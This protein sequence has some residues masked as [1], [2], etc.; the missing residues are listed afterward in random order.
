MKSKFI[1]NLLILSL[2]NIKHVYLLRLDCLEAIS[3]YSQMR[4]TIRWTAEVLYS[5]FGDI[6]LHCPNIQ[7]EQAPCL[8]IKNEDA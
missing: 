3:Y 4:D 8:L 1:L 7:A 5:T 6:I 2:S